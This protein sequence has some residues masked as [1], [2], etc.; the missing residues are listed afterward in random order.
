MLFQWQTGNVRGFWFGPALAGA[1]LVLFG[2]L[3]IAQP[4]LL[5]YLVA[6]LFIFAGVSMIGWSLHLRGR[7]TYRRMD[8][9]GPDEWST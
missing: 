6:G 1:M 7:T 9:R 8:E 5:A 3:I 4:A 2:V